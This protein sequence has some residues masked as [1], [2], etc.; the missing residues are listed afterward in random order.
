[1]FGPG[2]AASF[3]G[4]S[5]R[6]QEVGLWRVSEAEAGAAVESLY[7]DG[8]RPFGRLLLKRLG[9]LAV[10]AEVGAGAFRRLCAQGL[11]LRAV[12][13]ID[14][15]QL[16]RTCEA[17]RRFEVISEDAGEYTVLLAGRA[18]AFVDAAEGVDPYPPALWAA[19]R[20]HFAVDGPGDA[21]PLPGGRYACALA[22]AASEL[23]FLVGCSLGQVGHIVQLAISQ[24]QILGYAGGCVV[25]YRRCEAVVKRQCAALQ[26]PVEAPRRAGATPSAGA[27]RVASLEEARHCLRSILGVNGAEP[28]D[29]PLPNIKRFFRSRFGM[30]LSETSLGHTRL[31]DLLQDAAFSDICALRQ[32]GNGYVVVPRPAADSHE[33]ESC[34]STA[35]AEVCG[36]GRSKFCQDEPLCLDIL[37]PPVEA[38]QVQGSPFPVSTPSPT[39]EWRPP[40]RPSASGAQAR[41]STPPPP[42]PPAGLLPAPAPP[43]PTWEALCA[44]LGVDA[45]A[46]RCD[47][48]GEV[49]D[50]SAT[51]T[52]RESSRCFVHLPEQ[53]DLGA[54]ADYADFLAT[55]I[56]TP[57]P[58]LRLDGP[59][60]GAAK[61]V[62]SCEAAS[63]GGSGAE[64]AGTESPSSSALEE[65]SPSSALELDLEDFAEPSWSGVFLPTPS[66]IVGT[67]PGVAEQS[68]RPDCAQSVVEGAVWLSRALAG[69]T[70]LPQAG[71]ATA[72][73]R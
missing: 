19:L 68:G 60:W 72:L 39:Y 54:N 69:H 12:P 34:G 55:P 29:V 38:E 13:Q 7:A 66:P 58:L 65:R 6:S 67:R 1:M 45:G 11:P 71:G 17:S 62:A 63:D 41:G 26:C 22:L 24:Q 31:C 51:A 37:C 9:E 42:A 53:P 30:A 4:A 21:A 3:E 27:V 57:S 44:A 40:S 50:D 18:P 28:R 32:Q 14:R 36:R 70:R 5:R 47:A 10:A 49:F 16:R 33:V 23:P 52:A 2:F 8:L 73:A 61:A 48:V 46:S 15:V 25:P 64:E 56:S 35:D 20:E 59:T 43:L